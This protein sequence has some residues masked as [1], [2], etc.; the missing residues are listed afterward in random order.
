MTK[1]TNEPA[2]VETSAPPE[3]KVGDPSPVEALGPTGDDLLAAQ[4]KDWAASDQPTHL[5][6][7]PLLAA[8]LVVRE[9]NAGRAN[10]SAVNTVLKARFGEDTGVTADQ[11]IT[12]PEREDKS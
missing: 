12:K 3:Q 6:P 10:A 5:I 11:V 7:S 2:P 9:A 4:I 8:V 1:T